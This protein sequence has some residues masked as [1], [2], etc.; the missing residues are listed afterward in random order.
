MGSEWK[1]HKTPFADLGTFMPS[2]DSDV[3][4]ANNI[5]NALCVPAFYHFHFPLTLQG[6]TY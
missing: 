4:V 3:H 5:M 1:V 2:H 6:H